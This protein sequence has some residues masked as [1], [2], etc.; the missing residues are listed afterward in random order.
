[1]STVLEIVFWLAGALIVWT[2]LGYA[3]ALAVWARLPGAPAPPAA[4]PHHETSLRSPGR[5]GAVQLASTS[6]SP[7][8]GL[9]DRRRPRRGGR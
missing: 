8:C 6:L 4:E 1:M 2:Q 3:L 9:A 7:Q 5:G